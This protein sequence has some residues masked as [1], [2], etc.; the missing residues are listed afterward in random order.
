MRIGYISQGKLFVKDGEK[1]FR[2]IESQF[3]Q[4]I[5][6][7]AIQEYQRSNWKRSKGEANLVSGA[8]LW[9]VQEQDPRATRIHITGVTTGRQEGELLYAL[10]TDQVGGFFLYDFLNNSERRLFHKERFR[11]SDLQRHPELPLIVSAVFFPNGTSNI[12]VV[13][14]E[15]PI[16]DEATSGDSRDESPSWIPGPRKQIVFQSAGVGRNPQGFAVGFSPSTIEKLDLETGTLETVAQEPQQDLL[17]PK[18]DADGNLYF[19]RRPYDLHKGSSYTLWKGFMDTILLPFRFLRALFH[20]FNFMSMIYSN[21]ALSSKPLVPPGS[22][23]PESAD[24]KT[25]LLRGR[26]I[27]VKK[28]IQDAGQGDKELPALVPG[29]WQ[30]IRKSSTGEQRV[31]AKSVVGYDLVPGGKIV[32]T[33][34]SSMFL[35]EPDGSVSKMAK[36]KL[37]ENIVVLR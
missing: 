2:L 31:L 6:N 24:L 34:G 10:E 12:V 13:E 30:L 4:E 19:I 27:D 17:L 22:P 23:D 18:M 3:G 5:M 37:I 16:F 11:T 1:E 7:R 14:Q 15:R 32:Y 20:Y 26:V 9:N 36:G 8:R 33:D 29:S 35:I 28:A 21:K 25:V